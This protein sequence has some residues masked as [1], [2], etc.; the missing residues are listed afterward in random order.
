MHET[1]D[2]LLVV[3]QKRR[4]NPLAILAGPLQLAPELLQLFAEVSAALLCNIIIKHLL[5][6]MQAIPTCITSLNCFDLVSASISVG[7]K[8][9][10]DSLLVHI[11]ISR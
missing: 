11:Y 6:I 9:H 7:Y 2:P 10:K 1:L 3:R 4:L 5:I 8:K